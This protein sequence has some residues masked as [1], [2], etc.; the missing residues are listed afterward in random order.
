IIGVACRTWDGSETTKTNAAANRTLVCQ[1]LIVTKTLRIPFANIP[2]LHGTRAQKLRQGAALAP[3]HAG[4]KKYD[5]ILAGLAA[6]RNDF[7]VIVDAEP[8]EEFP[9]S[10]G[11]QEFVEIAKLIITVKKAVKILVT[12]GQGPAD[13]LSIVVEIA[14]DAE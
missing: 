8:L 1:P 5:A 10:S 11:I 13:D 3:L 6:Y 9:P 14:G 4:T 7:S 12:L 2:G